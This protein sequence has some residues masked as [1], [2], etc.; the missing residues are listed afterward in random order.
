[1]VCEYVDNLNELVTIHASDDVGGSGQDMYEGETLSYFDLLH[2]M[3]MES[4]NPAATTL[5]RAVGH[6]ML[7]SGIVIT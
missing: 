1:M 5:A 3:L 2:M 4:S 6:K 7:A